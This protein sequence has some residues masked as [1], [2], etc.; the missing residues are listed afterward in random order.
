M[1]IVVAGFLVSFPLQPAGRVRPGSGVYLGDGLLLSNQ[2]VLRFLGDEAY[3]RVPAW[4]YG[5]H[6][7]DAPVE[8]LIYE[9]RDIELAIS[10]L[11]PS[12]LGV[13]RV[14]TPCLSDRALKP[15]ETLTVTSS[16]HGVFPPVTARL[17]V[18][19][20]RPLMRRDLDPRMRNGNRYSAMTVITT[21]SA[22]QASRVGPGSSGAPVLNSNGELV[23]LVWTGYERGNGAAEVWIT[24]VSA[25]LGR[26]QAAEMPEDVR[27]AILD[28]RCIQ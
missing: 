23:G 27:Q 21:L 9:N 12:L 18:R 20:A 5:I 14:T 22:D 26:L 3:F 2:H 17:I 25:W 8:D 28:A 6:A 19:D 4:R 10:R 13:A 16:P 11:G 1:A 24:P 15:G 7:I